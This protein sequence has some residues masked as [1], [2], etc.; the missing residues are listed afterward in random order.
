MATTATTRQERVYA[1]LRS[2][3]LGGRLAPGQKLP[4]GELCETYEVSVG[5]AREALHRLAGQGLVRNEP[6]RGF[7]VVD[8]SRRDLQHLTLARREIETLTLRHS[9]EEGDADWEASVIAAHHRLSRTPFL[10]DEGGERVSER[11]AEAHAEFHDTLLVGCANPRLIG[12]ARDLRACSELYRRWSVPL[13]TE[14]SRDIAGEHR[15]IAD[16]AVARDGA[17]AA[18]LLG[19]HI[20]RT[21][22]LLL[23]SRDL[24][25]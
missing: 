8:L 13:D 9:I 24:V 15:A 19:A 10:D 4:F 23:T 20:Q 16:A 5:V 22:D 11:W 18:A 1:R 25:D 3:I 21:T 17:L 2:D 14:H 12:I 7:V 6:Q